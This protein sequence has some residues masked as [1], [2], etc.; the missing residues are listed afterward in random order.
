MKKFLRYRSRHSIF[1]PRGF[2][3]KWMPQLNPIS[4]CSH[5]ANNKRTVRLDEPRWSYRLR[6]RLFGYAGQQRCGRRGESHFGLNDGGKELP[7]IWHI[8]PDG[9]RTCSYCGSL[10][11]DDF[12][13]LCRR[14]IDQEGYRIEPSDKQY[15]IYVVQPGV[16]NA[17][18]GAIKY[19]TAHSPE[20][21]SEGDGLAFR[22]AVHVSA[23]RYEKILQNL[24]A[25]YAAQ[26]K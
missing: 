7:D 26:P 22:K 4:S 25:G 3:G 2:G 20:K 6:H 23:E 13:A 15:K 12:M 17:S 21:I 18:E 5:G 24:R 16:R 9:Y 19:Y 1:F 10:H 11:Y 8:G 14:A